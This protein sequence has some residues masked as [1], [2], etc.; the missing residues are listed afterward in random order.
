[1]TAESICQMC[2]TRLHRNAEG[3]RICEG[4]YLDEI[5]GHH[6]DLDSDTYLLFCEALG[7]ALDLREHETG[8]HSKRVACHTLVL[9]QHSAYDTAQ[10]KQIYWGALLH[11]L[12][13]IGIPDQILLKHGRLTNEEWEVMRQHPQRGYG[14]LVTLPFLEKAAQ[15][16]LCHEERFDGSGY[17][18]GLRGDAIPWSARLF[19]I[20]D[21]LDA[22]T[23]DRPYRV[24]MPFE[25]ARDEIVAMAGTQFDPA[26]VDL[27]LQEEPTL[28][29]MVTQKCFRTPDYLAAHAFRSI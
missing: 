25:R 22:I 20:I 29:E 1:M 3:Q 24:G 27:F 2:G 19:S 11:D 14:I 16:V 4:C 7:A 9:A 13:K 26:A 23:S 18:R 17:P 15:I 8:Q 21:T 10:L 6:V 28:R 12:G 5:R